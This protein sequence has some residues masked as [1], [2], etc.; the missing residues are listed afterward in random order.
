[1]TRLAAQVT[2]IADT[3]ICVKNVFPEKGEESGVR[4]EVHTKNCVTYW[5]TTVQT[6]FLSDSIRTEFY[7]SRV[8]ATRTVYR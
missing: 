8:M 4:R 5:G 7:V 6:A 1:M 2:L 3:T